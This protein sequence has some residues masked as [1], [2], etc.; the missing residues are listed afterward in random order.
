MAIKDK[1]R[2]STQV[3]NQDSE[4]NSP[5]SSGRDR[6]RSD[7]CQDDESSSSPKRKLSFS[8]TKE[9][10]SPDHIMEP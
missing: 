5:G 1:R 10:K 4:L 2:K 3:R 9:S 8:I 7:E 6:K